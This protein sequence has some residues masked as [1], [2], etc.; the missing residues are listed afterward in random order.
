MGLI[1]YV[2]IQAVSAVVARAAGTDGH[3]GWNERGRPTGGGERHDAA[4]PTRTAADSPP[5]VRKDIKFMYRCRF[6]H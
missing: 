5:G 6:S 3:A 2:Y 4:R 1:L